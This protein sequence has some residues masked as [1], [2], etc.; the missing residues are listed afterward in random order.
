M[1]P[2]LIAEFALR[3]SHV[4]MLCGGLTSLPVRPVKVQAGEAKPTQDLPHITVCA[5]R[6]PELL[7]SVV[8]PGEGGRFW[9]PSLG[10]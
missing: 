7:D 6:T 1:A 3:V 8:F 10:H 4:P 2:P 9:V 5:V